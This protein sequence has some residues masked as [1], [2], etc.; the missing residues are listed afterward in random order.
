MRAM[1]FADTGKIEMD[2][3]AGRIAVIDLPRH[4]R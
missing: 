1:P 3:L 4:H 2:R